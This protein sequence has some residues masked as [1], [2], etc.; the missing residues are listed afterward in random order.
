MTQIHYF[1][2]YSQKENLV[3]NNTLLLLSRLYDYNRLKFGKFLT[4]LGDEASSISEHLHLQFSQ[5]RVTGVSVVDGFIAQDSIKIVV[6]TKL[7]DDGFSVDQL[8]RHLTAFDGE[9]HRLFVLLSPG[10]AGPGADVLHKI[11]KEAGE[12]IP[13]LPT[14]FG[15]VFAA[16]RECLSDHDEDMLTILADFEVFCSDEGLLPRDQFTMFVPPCGQSF[17]DNEKYRLYYCPAHWHR[18]TARFLGVYADKSVRRLGRIRKI[19]IC[20]I[21]PKQENLTLVGGSENANA[22]ERQR[23]IGAA[24][25]AHKRG[26]NITHDHKFYLCDEMVKTDFRKTSSGGIQGHRYIDI[27][28]VLGLERLPGTVVE[29]AV[30]L[31]DQT[32]Q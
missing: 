6:E 5:Q 3:T 32:W 20:N 2:R 21:D 7:N 16:T 28:E 22:E 10:P 25:V 29:L 26:W 18:K 27:G 13:V 9:K 1:P 31:K 12:D 19:V 11:R 14:T 17:A 24:R 4:K 23:I 30:L 15:Q 8:R